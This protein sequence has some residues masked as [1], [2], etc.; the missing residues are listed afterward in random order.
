MSAKLIVLVIVLA[1]L[2]CCAMAA[3]YL[4]MQESVIDDQDDE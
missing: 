2:F 4:N 1:T 3:V